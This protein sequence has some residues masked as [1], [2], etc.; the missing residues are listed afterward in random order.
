MVLGENSSGMAPPLEVSA[1]R[2]HAPFGRSPVAVRV[3]GTRHLLVR[4]RIGEQSLDLGSHHST[5]GAYQSHRS[6]RHALG[7]L[8]GVAEHEDRLAQARRLLLHASGV[9]DHQ[10]AARHDVRELGVGEGLGEHD[11]LGVVQGSQHG[12]AHRLVAVQREQE[13][14]LGVVSRDVRQALHGV[15]HRGAPGLAT[16]GG[17]EHEPAVASELG[18]SVVGEGDRLAHGPLQGVDHGVAGDHDRCRVDRLALEVEPGGRGGCQMQGGDDT[19]EPAVGLLGK[20]RAQ[21]ARAQPGLDVYDGHVRR[22]SRPARQRTRSSCPPARPRRRDDRCP[23][24]ARS[25]A[26]PCARSRWAWHRGS[27]GPGRPR[28]VIAK[29]E[30]TWS[31]ISRCWPVTT[32]TGSRS[33][34][35][36]SAVT[37]GRQ[38]DGFGPGAVDHHDASP[39][40]AGP[41]AIRLPPFGRHAP[42]RTLREGLPGSHPVDLHRRRR[43]TS[44]T[45]ARSRTS[46]G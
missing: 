27:S 18:H 6:C 35:S 13:V 40:T 45:A 24:A 15:L 19:G 12:V 34:A 4:R 36:L 25:H 3:H 37:T 17:D 23:A 2:C 21:V 33:S 26:A 41:Y 7:P 22:G 46:A 1:D 14:D 43:W 9:G 20:R 29:N 38:L 10:A 32:T 30:L 28:G 8:R 11:V 44:C 42:G 16:M 5:V 31:S 39:H